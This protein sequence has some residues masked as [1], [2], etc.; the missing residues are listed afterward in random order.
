M[1][2]YKVFEQDRHSLVVSLR[3]GSVRA[4]TK[5]RG[6]EF[7]T[8]HNK[9]DADGVRVCDLWIRYNPAKDRSN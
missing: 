6:F 2:F 1:E 8:R 4:L 3:Q 9:D 5:E 7:H